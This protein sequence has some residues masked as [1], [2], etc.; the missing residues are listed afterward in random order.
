NSGFV[1]GAIALSTGRTFGKVWRDEFLWS[2]V[3]FMV[4]SSA[5]AVAAVVIARGYSW[6]ALLML[7]PVYMTYRTYELFVNRLEGQTRYAAETRR[8]HQETVEALLMARQAEQALRDE[9]ERLT[10]TLRSVGDG[11]IATDLDSTILSM[12]R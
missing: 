8:L 10:V 7:A 6:V 2:G 11:V 5:G 9:T 3:S 4:A 12:N 1:V